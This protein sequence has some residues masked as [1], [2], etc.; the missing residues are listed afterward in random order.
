MY[1]ISSEASYKQ[2]L[3]ILVPMG[4]YFQIQDDYLDCYGDPSVLGKIG[5]DILDNKCSWNINVALQ[6]ASSEQREV[7]DQSYGRK[8][9][10]CEKKVKEVFKQLDIAGRFEKYEAESYKNLTGLI[11]Q[12]DESTGVKK[13]VYTTFLNKVSAVLLLAFAACDAS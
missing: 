13:D 9:G 1:G 12:V 2:A 7:L 6:N 10:E 8:D 3:D 5:T 11:D 4:E